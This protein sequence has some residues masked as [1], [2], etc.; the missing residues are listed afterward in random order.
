MYKYF[1]IPDWYTFVNKERVWISERALCI[2]RGH[3]K[4]L[5]DKRVQCSAQRYY[6]RQRKR[7]GLRT[8]QGRGERMVMIKGLRGENC[9]KRWRGSVKDKGEKTRQIAR[10]RVRKL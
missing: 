6:E 3:T 4:S 5:V 10:E 9:D 2:N 1:V 7:D 8:V